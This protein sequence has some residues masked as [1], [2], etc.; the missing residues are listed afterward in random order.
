MLINEFENQQSNATDRTFQQ[1]NRKDTPYLFG[2]N[3]LDNVVETIHRHTVSSYMQISA[4]ALLDLS[5]V[6]AYGGLRGTSF[7]LFDLSPSGGGKDSAA[8]QSFDLLLN[9]IMKLQNERKQLHDAMRIDSDDKIPPKSFHCIHTTDVTPQATYRAFETTK[10]Q[11]PRLGEISN[12]MRKKEDSLMIFITESYGRSTLV[13]PNYKKDLGPSGDLIIDGISLHF[14][15]NSNIR[16]MGRSTLMFH[17]QGG[18]LNRCILLY[19]PLTRAFEDRPESYD[20]PYSTQES[21]HSEVESLLAYAQKYSEMV[22]P[23]M[24]RNNEEYTRFERE[25]YT[26]SEELRETDI[27]D[28]FK[29][30]IQNLNAIILTLHYLKCWQQQKW[31]DT[32]EQ[33]TVSLGIGFMRYLIEGYDALIDEIL[34]VKKDRRDENNLLKLEKKIKEL[35]NPTGRIPH[36][37]LY[38]SLH[39]SRQEY[40]ELLK[41]TK[42]RSDKRFLTYSDF[43]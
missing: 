28:I 24:P 27:A 36:R 33:S 20:I 39:L 40:D 22:K 37:E 2:I 1:K 31:L 6:L 26:R 10:A 38:R 14:Y 4:I 34:G 21:I 18:L 13:Q 5:Y 8:N 29:R 25:I 3:L 17:L 30:T 15:G 41:L 11:Y 7:Y 19:N 9:P 12:K 32:V 16:M 43:G 23:S 42:Y 35:A